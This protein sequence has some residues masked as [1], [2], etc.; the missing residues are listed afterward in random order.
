MNAC[1]TKLNF[2]AVIAEHVKAKAASEMLYRPVKGESADERAVR[3]AI[4]D[5]EA[6]KA[7]ELLLDAMD[8]V[9]GQQGQNVRFTVNR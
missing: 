4:A 6:S 1:W 7:R 2:P 9:T 8:R 3:M 5:R